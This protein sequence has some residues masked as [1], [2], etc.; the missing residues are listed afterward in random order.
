MKY[1]LK[2]VIF[3]VG[4]LLLIFSLVS[5]LYSQQEHKKLVE[6]VSADWRQ[7]PVFTVDKSGN[8]VTDLEPK[9]IQV[10]LNDQQVPSFTF[11]KRSFTITEPG[12]DMESAQQ[13]PINK[14]RVLFLLFDQA[15]SSETSTSLAKKIAKKIIK[16]AEEGT[17]FFVMIIDF[18]TGLK[19]IGE[20]SGDNKNQ[21]IDMIKKR[22]K[23]KRNPR[24]VN[25]REIT[26]M[27]GYEK[28]DF[29]FLYESTLGWNQ[30][31]SM[32]FIYAFET[33]YFFLNSIQDN[34][35]IYLFSEGMSYN[36]LQ[37]S[38]LS[39]GSIIIPSKTQP[40]LSAGAGS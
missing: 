17:H 21:L 18:F 14:N 30:R 33:L 2:N 25:I 40:T 6:E 1:I 12:K 4:I 5:F 32:G 39:R 29:P 8:P 37:T 35:F 36:I 26:A 27:P 31:K 3:G 28:D 34:K 11:Y 20:G 10:R 19:Y 7:A 16:D 38:Q 15:M 9:D 13:L 24:Y 22:V 23:K